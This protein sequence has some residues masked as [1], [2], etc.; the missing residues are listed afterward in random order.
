M[1][2]ILLFRNIATIGTLKALGMSDRGIAGAFLRVSA[3]V[4]LKGLLIGN[5]AA[6]LFALVQHLTH[7]VH[8]NPDNYFLSFVPVS[9]NL[10]QILAVDVLA[11]R[12]IMLMMLLPSLFIARV[13]PADTV[14][15]K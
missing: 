1:L 15:V 8:L 3:R 2:L 4:V 5:A 12:A 10:L 6:L 7:F 11:F 13:D 9:V 14:R